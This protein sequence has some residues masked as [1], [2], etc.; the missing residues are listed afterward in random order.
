M[1]SVLGGL[2]KTILY[3]VHIYFEGGGLQRHKSCHAFMTV[4]GG[5][6]SQ[7]HEHEMK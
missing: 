4:G 3:M 6:N 2:Q 7:L 1:S 5:G